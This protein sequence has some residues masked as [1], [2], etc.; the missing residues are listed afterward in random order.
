MRTFKE[1]KYRSGEGLG[2]LEARVCVGGTSEGQGYLN[3]LLHFC[4][5]RILESLSHF[6]KDCYP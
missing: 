3:I 2:V 4:V 6:R 1:E 5:V